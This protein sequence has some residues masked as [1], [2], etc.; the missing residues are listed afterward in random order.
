MEDNQYQ[1]KKIYEEMENEIKKNEQQYQ[2]KNEIEEKIESWRKN[3][4]I[5]LNLC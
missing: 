5:L 3:F 4:G 2:K 1:M